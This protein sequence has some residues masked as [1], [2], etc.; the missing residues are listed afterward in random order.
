MIVAAPKAASHS[1]TSCL[2]CSLMVYLVHLT[3]GL[4]PRL[5]ADGSGERIYRSVQLAMPSREAIHSFGGHRLPSIS[6]WQST[7]L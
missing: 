6:S 3:L 1:I 7:G 4:H 2:F 5:E